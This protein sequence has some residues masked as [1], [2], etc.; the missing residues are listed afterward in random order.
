MR[1]PLF[2]RRS[3]SQKWRLSSA[4]FTS[5]RRG[6]IV[7]DLWYES[8]Y[9][10]GLEEAKFSKGDWCNLLSISHRYECEGAR[11]R[12]IKE[13]S[14]LGPSVNDADKIDMTKK[15]GVEEWLVPACV[16]LVER[17]DPLTYAE[18]DKLGLVMTVQ[19]GEVRERYI[20]GKR[21]RSYGGQ[22]PDTPQLVKDILRIK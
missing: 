17:D 14:R 6:C 20:Q 1:P 5:G 4:S 7:H 3:A 11:E 19:L 9:R 10:Q 13:I 15:F 16:A 21:N 12:A 8:A 2:Y 22:P 18:A